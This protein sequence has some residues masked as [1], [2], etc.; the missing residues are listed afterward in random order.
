MYACQS[1]AL[2][3]YTWVSATDATDFQPGWTCRA[4]ERPLPGSSLTSWFTSWK[5]V[6]LI[7]GFP[8]E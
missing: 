5:I 6:K 3:G 7:Q 4:L 8:F 1:A 2:P